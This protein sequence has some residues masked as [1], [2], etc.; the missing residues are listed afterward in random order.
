MAKW[1]APLDSSHQICS[2]ASLEDVL[3]VVV[4]SSSLDLK[5]QRNWS[6][7]YLYLHNQGRDCKTDGA[8][9]F[10]WSNMYIYALERRSCC[11]WGPIITRLKKRR[12]RPRFH[13]Y[14]Y[15]E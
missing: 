7:F 5:K 1:R 8:I 15:N 12:N 14:L 9:R 2:S 3:I 10:S 6:C 4:G 11:S 13:L